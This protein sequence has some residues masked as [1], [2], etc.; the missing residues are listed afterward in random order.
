ML[1]ELG[2]AE[3]RRLLGLEMAAPPRPATLRRA[4]DPHPFVPSDPAV[5][6]DR[7]R[8]IFSILAALFLFQ[9]VDFSV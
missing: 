5:R 8:E 9:S 1:V 3:S 2:V 6:R 7:C 4:F